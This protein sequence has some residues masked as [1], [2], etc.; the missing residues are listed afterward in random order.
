MRNSNIDSGRQ[1]VLA[2]NYEVM[3]KPGVVFFLGSTPELSEKVRRILH[4]T[5]SLIPDRVR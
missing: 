4:G 5:W 3:V 1:V 2:D